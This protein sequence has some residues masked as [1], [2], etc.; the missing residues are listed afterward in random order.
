MASRYGWSLAEF[1]KLTEK[2]IQL[3]LFSLLKNKHAEYCNKA[4]LAGVSKKDLPQYIDPRESTA[5]YKKQKEQVLKNTF[6][7]LKNAGQNGW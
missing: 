4:M 3:I 2:Q 6:E 5:E 1:L 7:I